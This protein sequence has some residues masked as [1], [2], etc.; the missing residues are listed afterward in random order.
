MGERLVSRGGMVH[1]TFV[2]W[3]I[4]LS[5]IS[6]VTGSAVAQLERERQVIRFERSDVEPH[7]PQSSVYT[8]LQDRRGF[9]WFGTRE[10]LGRWDGYEMRTWKPRAFTTSSLP[11]NVVRRIVEDREGNLWVAVVADDRE[12]M[13]LA[14]LVA[15]DHERVET[16]PVTDA[17]I[18]LD[19]EGTAWFASPD[20]IRR[21]DAATGSVVSVAPRL[22]HGTLVTDGVF[23]ADGTLWLATTTQQVE[24]HDLAR[25][26]SRVIGTARPGLVVR[27]FGRILQD[28]D[29][30]LWLT[31][32][33]LRRLDPSRDSIAAV[34][35]LPTGSDT[36]GT[37][38]IV[39]DP[40]G[41]IWLAT[42]NGVHR[43]DPALT[44]IERHPLHLPGS[45]SSANWVMALLRDRSGAVWAGTVWGLHRWDPAVKAIRFVHHDAED[46]NTLSSGLVMALHEDT[47]GALWV[48]T[49]GGGVNR[50]DR[51]TG[52]VRRYRHAA[53]DARS[54]PHDWVWSLAPARTGGV[55]VG[56]D[57]GP[58]RIDPARGTF[59]RIRFPRSASED[60]S[61]RA[62]V[63]G[64]DGTLWI[65]TSSRLFRMAGG[66]V[67]EEVSIPA[68]DAINT[69]R[70]HAGRLW[71]GSSVGLVAYDP[72][73]AA[74]TS[75]RH[76]PSDTTTLQHDVVMA[77]HA[78]AS[79][80]L[81][82]GTHGGLDRLDPVTGVATHFRNPDPAT[83]G[84]VYSIVP[85]DGGRLWLGTNRG[86]VRFDPAAPEP[87]RFRRF[88]APGNLE[89]NRGAATRGSDGTIYFGGD[90]G[91][92]AFHPADLHENRYIPPVV[93]TSVERATRSGRMTQRHVG[94]DQAIRLAPDEY[95]VTFTAAALNYT[96]P[97]RNLYR[98]RLEGFDE[99]W[100]D[101]GTTRTASYTNLPPGRYTL[102]VVASNDDGLWNEAGIAVPVVVDPWFWETWWF[103][104]LLVVLAVGAVS[105]ATAL[106]Q[107]M[108]HRRELEAVAYARALEGERSR[109]SGDV[110]DE[111]G[112][113]LTEI[114]LLSEAALRQGTAD[115]AL[116]GIADRARG[117]IASTGEI[118]WAINP[119]NDRPD[120]LV[121]YL[122]EYATELL[123]HAG[124]AAE[125][126]FDTAGWTAPASPDFRRQLFLVL[127]ESL[128]NVVR[129]AGATR[130][131]VDLAVRD[132]RVRLTV[133]DDGRGFVAEQAAGHHLGL[134]NLARRG[135]ALGGAV[136]IESVPGTGTT[137][138]LDV[139][140]PTT[141]EA[142]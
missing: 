120:R 106:V 75:F 99:Q 61:V 65:G 44:T 55:W 109:I 37:S 40:D 2:R 89:F 23:G 134:V 95:T 112:A 79:G 12:V 107:R 73:T 58:V 27:R 94:E 115:R 130:V 9:L 132:G 118:I 64:P 93:I 74:V 82:V 85:D 26:S 123:E 45:P 35:L 77:I 140:L 32:Y 121:P 24:R 16:I 76:V 122:R 108:R 125:L 34:P 13:R 47:T 84:V 53:G 92:N 20:S 90:A 111:V 5:A 98:F 69:L 38:D 68:L 70:F 1:R 31:G 110:H 18:I 105:L 63:P 116:S 96:A 19:A 41:W 22:L 103:R 50:I 56:T 136:T 131:Q 80:A 54:L 52:A 137:V 39:Q 86:L 113:G 11:D 8:M 14:R 117:L 141:R 60:N 100:R 126:R 29:G 66:G 3:G 4:V 71:I 48:G 124:L 59:E 133:R 97:S 91:L 30:M 33:G 119:E 104:A 102:R 83:S 25:G 101:A 129:H 36:L 57:E 135:V 81:W 15:P 17:A 87:T 114:A 127:K 142:T 67:P 28:R 7:L 42:F 10:G 72:A 88:D 49:L 21:F 139:P 46:R 138:S 128:T 62:L 43:F 78:E 51:V 6:G